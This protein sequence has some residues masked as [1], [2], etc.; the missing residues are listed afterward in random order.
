MVGLAIVLG[1]WGLKTGE[2]RVPI[3]LVAG[4]FAFVFFLNR[5][6]GF[7]YSSSLISMGTG[8][9]IA[10][11]VVLY[12]FMLLGM[13]SQ[14]AYRYFDQPRRKRTKWDWHLFI[15]PIFVSPI[16]F[17][18]LALSFT[19]SGLDLESLT[20]PRLMIFFVAFENGFFWK[21]FFDLRRKEIT[22]AQ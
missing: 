1:L 8:S 4:E 21:E 20:A 18:P 13:F 11:V 10:L 6:F 14:Y 15:A 16:V 2:W 5:L 17:L 3:S 9:S 19:S 12:I 7:P 22:E